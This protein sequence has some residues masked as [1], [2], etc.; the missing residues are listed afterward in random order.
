MRISRGVTVWMDATKLDSVIA[1]YDAAFAAVENCFTA[2]NSFIEPT[3]DTHKDY[4]C[5]GEVNPL[6][7]ASVTMQ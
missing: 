5:F 2:V 1:V 7:P 3:E 6:P 4:E